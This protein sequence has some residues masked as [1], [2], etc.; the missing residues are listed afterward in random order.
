MT[1][2]DF[3]KKLWMTLTLDPKG[4][5]RSA[6]APDSLFKV[7]KDAP[8][9]NCARKD[10]FKTTTAKMLWISQWSRPNVQLS[11]AHHC[12]RVKFPTMCD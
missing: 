12:T 5:Y 7:N 11:T 2:Y 8:L 10:R 9:L 6:L 1:Q 3:I 4:N